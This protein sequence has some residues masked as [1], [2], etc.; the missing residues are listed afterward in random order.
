MFLKTILSELQIIRSC[1]L[2]KNCFKVDLK[3]RQKLLLRKVFAELLNSRFLALHH[4]H[5]YCFTSP[6]LLGYFQ[7]Q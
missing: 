7:T 1:M 6:F 2:Q 4:C 5:S 3:T